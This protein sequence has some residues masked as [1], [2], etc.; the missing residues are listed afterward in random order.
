VHHMLYPPVGAEPAPLEGAAAAAAAAA[1]HDLPRFW[2]VL[3]VFA[4]SAIGLV[5]AAV[6]LSIYH[7]NSRLPGRLARSSTFA[8]LYALSSGRYFIDEIYD[9]AIV[10]PVRFL[11]G[12]CWAFGDTMIIEFA[13]LRGLV[14]GTL[15]GTAN[16]LRRVGRGVVNAYAAAV[17]LGAAAILIYL[18]NRALG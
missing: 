8:G 11:A 6:V 13:V 7:R 16:V 17:F 10:R 18:L 12:I 3:N 1:A 14:A 2:A 5:S 15:E 4:A 9:A